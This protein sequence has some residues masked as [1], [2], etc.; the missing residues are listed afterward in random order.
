MYGPILAQY[1]GR[2]L[3]S[4]G[5]PRDK[6]DQTADFGGTRASPAVQLVPV[7]MMTTIWK[8]R[9]VLRSVRQFQPE[10]RGSVPHAAAISASVQSAQALSLRYRREGRYVDGSGSKIGVEHQLEERRCAQ[11]GKPEPTPNEPPAFANGFNLKGISAVLLAPS[12]ALVE[13]RPKL[14]VSEI[15]V[16]EP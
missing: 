15:L 7:S 9:L 6:R 5:G 13:L 3:L 8:R 10:W 2:A 11:V 12:S 1:D 4:P 16:R 14:R